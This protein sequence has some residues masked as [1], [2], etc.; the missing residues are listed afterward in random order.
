MV[1]I[2][3]RHRTLARSQWIVHEDNQSLMAVINKPLGGRYDAR[4]HIAIRV[5]WMRE[6][7]AAGILRAIYVK[8]ED[9]VV[10]T[11]TKGLS[12]E[13]FVRHRD[14]RLGTRSVQH[15]HRCYSARRRGRACI[16]RMRVRRTE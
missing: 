13:S 8:S 4:K 1:S 11:L 16:R 12:E 15:V 5:L 10:D 3:E 7:V 2:R 14:T 9:Q 6:V